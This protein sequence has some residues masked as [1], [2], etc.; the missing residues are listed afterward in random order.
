[1]AASRETYLE[2]YEG[3][4]SQIKEINNKAYDWLTKEFPKKAWCKHTK[5]LRRRKPDEETRPTKLRRENTKNKCKRC[6]QYGH[7]TQ[8]CKEQPMAA[9][10][11]FE[12]QDV[13][14]GIP[15]AVDSIETSGFE[16][17]AVGFEIPTTGTTFVASGIEA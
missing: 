8:T 1:M 9:V 14:T 11:G 10:D 16:A 17:Q 7:N 4:M 3:K 5:K 12:A 2:A 13:G 15:T 6:L